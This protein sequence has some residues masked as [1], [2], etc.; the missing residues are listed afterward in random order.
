MPTVVQ[1]PECQARHAV[2][3]TARRVNLLCG[4]ARALAVARRD[5]PPQPAREGAV[6][7]CGGCGR[8]Y[9]PAAFRDATDVLCTCGNLLAITARQ[10]GESAGRRRED[11]ARSLSEG[12]L[13]A[14]IDLC[15]MM[16]AAVDT[17]TLLRT[18]LSLSARI[19]RAEGTSILLLSDSGDELVFYVV[20]GKKA[21]D[22]HEQRLDLNEGIAGWVVRTGRSAV[23]NDTA[24]DERFAKRFDDH[25]RF[26]TDSI[27]CVPLRTQE[28]VIGALEAVNKQ[29]DAGFSEHDLALAEAIAGQAGE[30][31]HR[32]RLV[33]Q[34]VR[35]QRLAAVGET[36]AGLAHCIKNI[37]NGLQGGAYMVNSGIKKERPETLDKGWRMVERNIER[38]SNLAL[39]M[40]NLSKDREPVLETADVNELIRDVAELMRERAASCR[41]TLRSEPDAA[42]QPFPFDARAMHRCVMNLVG[43]AIDA[44]EEAGG[45]V[46]I[47]TTAGGADTAD[48]SVTDNGCGMSPETQKK[49]FASFFSTKGS[50]GTGLG[51]AVT[52]KIL[53]EH[54]GDLFVRSE[55]GVGST[56][57]CRLPRRIR[58]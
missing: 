31:V 2:P 16:N 17:E 45:E 14:L 50:R 44:C 54:G 5:G 18:I 20:T 27:L 43:N 38:V 47:R 55:E 49:L 30:A 7:E 26:R 13:N 36:V 41:V 10:S 15:G 29:G 22:L 57:T 6:T 33:E 56:F 28:K 58:S 9:D 37:L 24:A 42:L 48:L 39:D 25:T 34:N 23:V 1:C 8:S 19:L 21:Q 35:S 12:E 32:A 46:V 4:C 3:D 40:L 51:L 52:R 11:R 53:R